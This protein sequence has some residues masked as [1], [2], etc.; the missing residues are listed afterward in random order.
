MRLLGSV[1]LAALVAGCTSAQTAE[2]PSAASFP[3]LGSADRCTALAAPEQTSA[4]WVEEANGLPGYCEVTGT[5]HPV[6]GSNIDAG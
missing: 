2:G 5:L 4:K 1:A 3:A 6:A